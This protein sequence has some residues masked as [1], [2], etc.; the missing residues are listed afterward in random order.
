MTRINTNVAALRG[1]RSLNKSTSLL[2]TSLTRLST[3]MKINSGKDNPS[4]LIASETLRSQVSAIE[5]SIKNSNRASN[6]IATAD[7]ALGEVTNLLNQVRGLVQEGLNEGAL[8]QDEIEA[9]QLQ[10]DTALSAINRISANTSFAGDK[11][12]DGSKAFRTQASATDSAKLSDYQVNEAVFGSSSSITLDATVVTAAT[13][14]SLDYSAVDGGLASATT[15]EVGG[16]SGSQVLFLGA[17]SSLDNVKD[18]VNG[19]SDITGVTATKTNKVASNLSFNNA[20][21][22]NSGL[23]FTDARTSDS[24]LG[25]TGQNIKVQ[26]VD[27]SANSA[28]ANISFSNTNTDITI[29]VSLGTLANGDISSNAA[30]IKTLLDGNADVNALISTAQEGDGSGVV[31]AEAAAA[32]SGGTNAYLT[33]SAGNYGSDEFV[34]VNVLN[35]TFN[36]VD[37]VTD[38]NALQR[39][40]GTDIVTRINGQV[41]QGSGLTAN[42]RSQQLDA[43]FSFTSAANT[44]NNTA[45]L[46]ITGGG[47]LFQI[48]QDVSAAGQIGIGI[49]AVNTARLGGVSGKLFEIGSGGG[50][51]LLDVGPSVPGSDLVNIIEE[52][53]NRVSTL[54]GRLGAVQKNVIETNVSSLGVALENISEARSQIVDTDFAVETAN[55][56][57][58]Q[59]L[60]QAGIS[61]LSIANQNPQQ[62]L[63]LLR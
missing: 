4:G 6:V 5:Q 54:R 39:A 26:F 57:K 33:F 53:I 36:T 13:Q 8:S 41:A 11:L 28:T 38:N 35:G 42:I 20:N 30:S 22:T 21:A 31:E 55:M 2:D 15:I 43:S 10:I 48:G 37:N 18:A 3:G 44:V 27:P 1:L 24:V 52:S 61:V 47:S 59:I 50:K 12:I 56:T 9:N 60:N 34:D 16:K 29:V 46:T 25:D 17:S 58:A 7:S 49:E 51:S 62:V 45:S 23:T 32:L 19:V 40:I 14:A 63:S